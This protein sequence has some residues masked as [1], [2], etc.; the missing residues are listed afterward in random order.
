MLNKGVRLIEQDFLH[1]FKNFK[2]IKK[3]IIIAYMYRDRQRF[4]KGASIPLGILRV[5]KIKY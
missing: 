1:I 3:L 2:E 5:N 4:M